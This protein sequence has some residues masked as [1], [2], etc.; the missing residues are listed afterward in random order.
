MTIGGGLIIEPKATKAKG[1]DEELI[2]HLQRMEVGEPVVIVEEDLL[3][4]FDLPRKPEE[5]AHDVNLPLAETKTLI[6]NLIQQGKIT[7]LDEKRGFYYHQKNHEK[8]KAQIVENLGTYHNA[9]PTGVGLSA[10][11][12][13]KNIS[14]GL[15]KVLLDRTLAKMEKE[16]IVRLTPDGKINLF[17]HKVVVDKDLDAT[18][19]KIE[20]LF[21]DGGYKPPSYQDMIDRNLGPENVVKKAYRYMLDTGLLV[22]AGEGIVLHQKHVKAAEQKLIE[23]LKANKEIRVSQFRD[24]LDASR[25]FVLPLL[26][27]FDTRGVTIKRGDVRVLGQKYR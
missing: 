11:E 21:T 24:L 18:I 6:E 17:E 27:Y 2:S 8:L 14:R 22:N 23:Y 5:I 25:K 12:L 3:A 13:L 26:T 15:D 7:C 19:K 10:L 9:N 20:Q 1:F 4:N 16:K